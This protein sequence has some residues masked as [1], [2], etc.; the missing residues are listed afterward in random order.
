MGDF[1]TFKHSFNS[2]DLI[3]MLPG[4]QKMYFEKGKKFKGYQRLD[5][6]AY[7]FDDAKHPVTTDG[8]QVCM[9]KAVFDMMKPLLESQDYIESFD[10][11]QGEKV[12]YDFDL[13]RHNAQIPIPNG[14]I[15]SWVTL[16]FPFL[17]T[18]LSVPWL[19]F[20]KMTP[21]NGKMISTFHDKIL[22][23][24]TRRYKNPYID[25]F[26]LKEHTDKIKFIGL[27]DEHEE[28]CNQFNIEIEHLDVHNFYALA[29]IIANCRFFVGN[30]SLCWH[31][32]DATKQKRI[33]EICTAFPNCF[34]TGKD[35]H[36][37]VSQG[38]LEYQFNE[39]LKE[40]A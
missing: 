13:T 3:T 18:D 33:L 19:S 30:Q 15:H 24:R 6:P 2:G 35:G 10:V 20:P 31:L 22:I 1:L 28:F 21:I 7:Y 12:T 25:Y 37:F 4:L 14:S 38:S 9:N 36:S 39:L 34:P 27:K 17:E 16:A 8:V 32:A 11:W 23:N 26:F 29:Y 40:T 5:M